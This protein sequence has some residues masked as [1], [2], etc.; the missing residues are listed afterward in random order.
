MNNIILSPIP[1]DELKN[2]LTNIVRHELKNELQQLAPKEKSEDLLIRKET[3]SLLGVSLHT[4]H[5]WTTSG[6]IPAYRIGSRVRYKRL[7]IESSLMQIKSAHY[8]KN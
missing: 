6:K 4:L 2:A 3:A 5:D 1:F 7:E 8:F